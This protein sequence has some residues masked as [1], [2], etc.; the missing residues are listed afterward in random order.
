[1]SK[2]EA[3]LEKKWAEDDSLED[4]N[5][6]PLE[7]G[8]ETPGFSF[9]AGGAFASAFAAVFVAGL[10]LAGTLMAGRYITDVARSMR[11]QDEA[12]GR[13]GSVFEVSKFPRISKDDS[14]RKVK[15]PKPLDGE[16]L[17]ELKRIGEE[18]RQSFEIQKQE[19]KDENKTVNI[20]VKADEGETVTMEKSL[21]LPPSNNSVADTSVTDK[22]DGNVPLTPR[23]RW[24]HR[25]PKYLPKWPRF[26]SRKSIKV[27]V[28]DVAKAEAGVREEMK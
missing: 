13:S 28:I 20:E 2:A 17:Q 11:D 15:E 12:E 16:K 26:L 19:V 24:W 4:V 14:S 6:I 18:G 21:D 1:M 23:S 27:E 8:A 10:G 9:V 7:P 25:L 5:T 22:V 3:S